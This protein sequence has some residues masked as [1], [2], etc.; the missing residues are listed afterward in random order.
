MR[1]H[2][3]CSSSTR[4][5]VR[6]ADVKRSLCRREIPRAIRHAEKRRTSTCLFADRVAQVSV[7]HY[8]STIPRSLRPQH[9]CVATIVAHDS[10]LS[11]S[12]NLVVVSMGVGTKF[13]TNALLE[14][15]NKANRYGERVRDC[16][17]EVLARRAF[18]RYVSLEI[19]IDLQSHQKRQTVPSSGAIIN[20]CRP[21]LGHTFK[22]LQRS[23]E[24][25]IGSPPTYRLREG[26]TLHFYTSSSPCG[27]SVLK[28]FATLKRERFRGELGPNEWPE[29]PHTHLPGHAVPSGEFA[30]L[31]KKDAA[32]T[33]P[34]E[35][36][37]DTAWQQQTTTKI[38]TSCMTDGRETSKVTSAPS[39]LEGLSKKQL[40]WPIHSWTDWCPPGTTTVWSGH[41]TIHTCSDK[42]CRWHLLGL[43]GS[44]LSSVFQQQATLGFGRLV[45]LTLTVGRKLSGVTCR[46]AVCCRIGADPCLLKTNSAG[47]NVRKS[48][49]RRQH[50]SVE[51]WQV[52]HPSVLGT[53]VYLDE[54]ATV[55][56]SSIGPDVRFHCNLAWAW[57]LD[58]N[59]GSLECIDA[60]SGWVAPD[61]TSNQHGDGHGQ[62]S[63]VST[64][65]LLG[66]FREIESVRGGVMGRGRGTADAPVSSLTE[67]R[68]FKKCIS[69]SYEAHKERLLTKHPVLRQWNRRMRDEC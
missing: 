20:E 62:Q 50:Q 51:D 32:P 18:R 25:D 65:A 8:H 16:H 10:T 30:L 19:L 5:L 15:E 63:Q 56:T 35:S 1:S 37:S 45:P 53:S 48:R 22:L 24:K 60:A 43:Q 46:R 38:S 68:Q 54:T 9:T 33:K 27:N 2:F 49:S 17:A 13:L 64:T 44:L 40:L 66:L 41:G 39:V 69:R 12:N 7:D 34:S 31:V 67:L 3:F 57:W 58:N 4:L 42:L 55:E 61:L 6:M 36:G 26:V 14:D 59:E 21:R 28:R 11:S 29:E 23:H 47:D 52:H